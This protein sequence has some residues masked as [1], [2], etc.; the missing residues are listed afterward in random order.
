QCIIFKLSRRTH[1][2]PADSTTTQGAQDL[3]TNG[4]GPCD[5]KRSDDQS[6]VDAS[7]FLAAAKVV[8]NSNGPEL[9]ANG[10][11]GCNSEAVP[12]FDQAWYSRQVPEGGTN[13]KDAWEHYLS[14]GARAGLEP[15][16]LF[17]TQ[18]YLQ[19]CPK[20]A[21]EGV[22]PLEH[23]LHCGGREAC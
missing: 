21:T 17:D 12:L 15:H 22:N 19:Q 2:N 5:L 10:N 8:L 7:P 13:G 23:Y 4:T 6:A 14:V 16:P 18:W 3:A 11:Q 20:A 1:G 9:G